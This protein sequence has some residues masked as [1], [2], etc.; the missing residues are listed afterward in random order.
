MYI[1]ETY[2]STRLKPLYSMGSNQ[3]DPFYKNC[4]HPSESETTLGKLV[5]QRLTD[6]GKCLQKDG[7][8]DDCKK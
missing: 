8:W 7:A 4:C 5:A 1:E 3:I 6:I 2:Q